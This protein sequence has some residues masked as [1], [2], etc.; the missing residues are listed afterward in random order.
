M[1]VPVEEPSTSN[2]RP[3][4]NGV[5]YLAKCVLRGSAVLQVVRGHIRSSDFMDVVFGKVFPVLLLRFSQFSLN[6]SCFIMGTWSEVFL[7]H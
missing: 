6:S 1:A 4:S 3:V 2:S 7:V 5:H